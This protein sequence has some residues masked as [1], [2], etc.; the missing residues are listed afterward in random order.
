VED[1]A[2]GMPTVVARTREGQAMGHFRSALGIPPRPAFSLAVTIAV[3]SFDDVEQFP[4]VRAVQLQ[5]AALDD[6]VPEAIVI[7]KIVDASRES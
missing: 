4:E 7:L 3:D 1:R 6:P 2:S 5:V